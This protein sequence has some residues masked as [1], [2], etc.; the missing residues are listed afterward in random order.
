M[1]WR[2]RGAGAKELD[3]VEEGSTRTALARGMFAKASR[4]VGWSSATTSECATVE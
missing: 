3:E 4:L 2:R 1:E